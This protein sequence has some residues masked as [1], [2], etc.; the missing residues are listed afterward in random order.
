[1]SGPT[2]LP[3]RTLDAAATEQTGPPMSHVTVGG[4]IY[5]LPNKKGPSSGH[6]ARPKYSLYEQNGDG[7]GG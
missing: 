4:D 6:P 7:G 3:P 1:M 2:W 5:R